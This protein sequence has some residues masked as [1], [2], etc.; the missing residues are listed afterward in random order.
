MAR[1]RGFTCL[2]GIRGKMTTIERLMCTEPSNL[3]SLK[4]HLIRDVGPTGAM[5]VTWCS[6]IRPLSWFEGRDGPVCQ[7]CHVN[8]WFSDIPGRE[9]M[10]PPPS[11]NNGR[12][13]LVPTET[14]TLRIPTPV[15]DIIR[16]RAEESGMSPGIASRR[17]TPRHPD[18]GALLHK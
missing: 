18:C 10:D 7:K 16:R 15:M 6:L 13:A 8:K 3:N 17:P 4:S 14:I 1:S 12:P 5:R 11:I 2:Q 9:E